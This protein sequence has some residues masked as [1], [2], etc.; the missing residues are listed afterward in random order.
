MHIMSPL[1]TQTSNNE[2]PSMSLPSNRHTSYS[3]INLVLKCEVTK[4]EIHDRWYHFT[5]FF[6]LRLFAL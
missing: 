5:R 6:D 1:M 4:T 3:S 2:L